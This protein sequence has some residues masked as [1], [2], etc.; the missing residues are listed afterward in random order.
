V[1]CSRGKTLAGGSIK[2]MDGARGGALSTPRTP[3]VSILHSSEKEPTLNGDRETEG[4]TEV[5]LPRSIWQRLSEA[6]LWI[7]AHIQLSV[8]VIYRVIHIPAW[9]AAPPAVFPRPSLSGGNPRSA[10]QL[11]P[12]PA[13][14]QNQKRTRQLAKKE[15]LLHQPSVEE[16]VEHSGLSMVEVL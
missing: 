10:S 8:T 15:S 12:G 3:R 4:Q 11:C 14:S 5:H 9:Q 6:T 2:G 13:P 1:F 16:R 7:L